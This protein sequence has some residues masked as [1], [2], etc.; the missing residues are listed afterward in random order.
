MNHEILQA[1]ILQF[2]ALFFTIDAIGLIPIFISLT[3]DYTEQ[4]KIKVIKKGVS[5]AF[6]VL[7]FFALLGTQVLNLFGIT[8]GAFRIAGGILLLILAIELVLD[9]PNA[10]TS[11]D[12]DDD[13]KSMDISVFPLAVPLLS[14]PASISMLIMFMK[15]AEHN[16]FKQTLTMTALFVNM[17]L[18]LIILL[19]ASNICKVLG[20]T[21]I[22][23]VNRI[24]GIILAA[25]AC[26][27]II[28]GLIDAFNIKEIMDALQIHV[29][30]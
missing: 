3:S 24:F 8:I 9:K 20:K 30:Q 27:F 5:T 16:L 13:L 14:G 21:G 17:V 23:I 26:Q 11:C 28:N 25:M 18:C 29:M 15:Q 7:L 22:N 12:P 6:A 19:F 10:P 2:T 4:M 1:F